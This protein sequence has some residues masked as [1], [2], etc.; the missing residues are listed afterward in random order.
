MNICPKHVKQ[1][2]KG[3]KLFESLYST[4]T[5]FITLYGAKKSSFAFEK[6]GLNALFCDASW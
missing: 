1:K 2:S 3:Q 6:K 4:H 5:P